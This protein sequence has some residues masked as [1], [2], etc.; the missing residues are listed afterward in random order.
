MPSRPVR[1]FAP[2]IVRLAAGLAFRSLGVRRRMRPLVSSAAPLSD[3]QLR[4]HWSDLR[5]PGPTRLWRSAILAALAVILLLAG[6]VY[7]GWQIKFSQE[8]RARAVA[9]TAGDPDLGR[10]LTMRYGCAS[11]HTIPG[12]PGADGKVGPSLQSLGARVYIAGVTPNTPETLMTWIENPRSIDP[13]TAMPVTGISREEA[14][15]VAAYLYTL[16]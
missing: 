7:A 4:I 5:S 12:V 8:A 9:L 2:F 15:D 1:L 11:C 10:V 13:K 16:R 14:R 3:A 6:G